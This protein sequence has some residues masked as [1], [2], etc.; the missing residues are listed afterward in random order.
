MVAVGAAPPR[1]DLRPWPDPPFG[2]VGDLALRR[3][4]DRVST[5][6]DHGR[7][8]ASIERAAETAGTADEL[9][10]TVD[11]ELR[12]TLPYDGA[13]WFG[14]DPATLLPTAPGRI[15]GFYASYCD[16]FWHRE[17]FEHDAAL[18]GD[19]ARA[20]VPVAALRL[21]LGGNPARSQRF[22]DFLQPH[23]YDDELRAVLRSGD[24]SWGMVG[25]YRDSGHDPFDEADV[26]LLHAVSGVL[27]AALRRHAAGAR[28]SEGCTV[29]PGVLLFG[30]DG[31]LLSANDEAACWLDSLYGSDSCDAS[32]VE[33]LA[34]GD[35]DL[36]VPTPFHA[37]VAR[38]RAVAEGIDRTPARLRMR[39]PN[40]RWLLVHA[41]LLRGRSPGS[42]V[43][44]VV[45]EPAKSA[46]VAPIMLDAHALSAR[47]RDVVSAIARGLSTA[48]IASTLFLSPHTVRDHVKAVFEKLG[49]SSRGE[50]V[51]KLFA[52]HY[53]EPFHD[54]L[55]H[56]SG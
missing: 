51:A 50:L 32:S 35:D 46:E 22:R 7:A 8:I 34:A 37:L 41:S 27:G 24:R 43:I 16:A 55:V 3:Y 25:L 40:G 15:D 30:H 14:V 28:T 1:W 47:E 39:D 33:R 19:L 20:P 21:S 29:S 5:R 2:G 42:G 11:N 23:G 52:E 48:D 10:E 4:G 6:G 44:T 9:L 17:F 36:M 56:V 12:R 31:T 49:V 18:F 54:R 13:M 45:I 38:A 26:A 53:T